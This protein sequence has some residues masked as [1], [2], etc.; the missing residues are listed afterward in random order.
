M[1]IA[2]IYLKSQSMGKI[3]VIF[4]T[5]RKM[6]LNGVAIEMLDGSHKLYLK[7]YPWRKK[8]EY[9]WQRTG[10]QLV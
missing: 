6:I 10:I 3:G 7:I 1:M 5:W 9:P 2:S 8:L 4:Q